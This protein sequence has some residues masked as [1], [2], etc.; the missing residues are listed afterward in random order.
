MSQVVRGNKPNLGSDG[1][2]S[3]LTQGGLLARLDGK[4]L[5]AHGLPAFP[6]LTPKSKKGSEAFH[7]DGRALPHDVSAFMRWA[8]SDHRAALL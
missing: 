2:T 1:V 4:A 5:V 8:C 3:I 7:L 6:R